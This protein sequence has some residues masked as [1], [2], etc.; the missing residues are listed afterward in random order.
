ME[1]DGTKMVRSIRGIGVELALLE[2]NQSM[3]GL[4]QKLPVTKWGGW[5]SNPHEI[6]LGGF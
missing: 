1:R 4:F 6:A 3:K 2:K 5:E